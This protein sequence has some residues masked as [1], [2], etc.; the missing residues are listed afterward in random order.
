MDDDET[1]LHRIRQ[2]LMQTKAEPAKSRT[3]VE[4]F[5]RLFSNDVQ[6]EKLEGSDC[7]QGRYHEIVPRLYLGD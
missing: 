6:E 7:V 2:L 3:I 1:N 5:R 4:L